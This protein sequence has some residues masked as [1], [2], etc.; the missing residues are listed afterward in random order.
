ME[1]TADGVVGISD[2]AVGESHR[3]RGVATLLLTEA[4][5]FAAELGAPVMVDTGNPGLRHVLGRLGF[6]RTVDEAVLVGEHGALTMP[7]WMQHGPLRGAK[8]H[9]NF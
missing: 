8:L 3:R 4:S 7:N 1:L 6:E 9:T 5:R 2:V